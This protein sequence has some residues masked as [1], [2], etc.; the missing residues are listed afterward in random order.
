MS[1]LDLFGEVIAEKEKKPVKKLAPAPAPT[2]LR[3]DVNT[4][5]EY[6]VVKTGK[7]STLVINS[8]CA[9]LFR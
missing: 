5:R 2:A 6:T 9:Y 1:E 4:H 3:V 7:Y 8:D